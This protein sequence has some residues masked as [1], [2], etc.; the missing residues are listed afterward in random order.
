MHACLHE[1]HELTTLSHAR[2]HGLNDPA[3]V[4]PRDRLQREYWECV[5][6]ASHPLVTVVE[7]VSLEPWINLA[8]EAVARFCYPVKCLSHGCPGHPHG[9]DGACSQT[10]GTAS[11]HK[12]CAALE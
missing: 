5:A 1:D 4:W 2:T 9:G 3:I 8:P 7:T 12:D 6:R 10:R 11:P